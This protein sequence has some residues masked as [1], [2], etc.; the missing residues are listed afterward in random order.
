MKKHRIMVIGLDGLCMKMIQ[1]FASEGII[2]NM[3]RLCR[4]GTLTRMIP[5]VP[6]QTPTNWTTLATGAYPG[7]HGITVWGTHEPG[8]PIDEAFRAEAMSSNLCRAEYFW[9]AAARQGMNSLLVNYVGYPPTSER[10]SFIEW[11]QG[12]AAYYFQI[13]PPGAVRTR[14]ADGGGQEVTFRTA[15]GWKNLPR[16]RRP[17]LETEF[18][19]PP[20]RGGDPAEFHVALIAR[21][22]SGYDTAFVGASKDATRAVHCR[23]GAWSGWLITP[24][25]V[26]SR[27]TEGSVRFKLLDLD[28]RADRVRLYHSQVYPLDQFTYPPHLGAELTRKFGP[29]VHEA[30]WAARH[31]GDLC[32]DATCE[33]E[34]TYFAR[35]VG[36]AARDLFDKLDVR[37]YYQH[38]HLLDS[39]NHAYLSAIDPYGIGYGKRSEKQGW[40][41]FRQGYRMV[42]RMVGEVVKAAD[43]HT[44]IA[45]CSDHSDVPNRRAVSLWNLFLK[46]GWVTLKAG[47]DG[48][49]QIDWKRTKVHHD[50]NHLWLN[51]RGRDPDGCVKP[52]REYEA[53]REE[54]LD[55]MIGLKDRKFAKRPIA[56]ALKKEDAACLGMYGP[57]AGDIVFYYAQGYRWS[58]PEVFRMGRRA[59]IFDDPGGA[60]H[61]PQIPTGQTEI[62]DNAAALILAGPG[63]RRGYV[64]DPDQAPPMSTADLVPTLAHLA[65]FEPPRHCEGKVVHDLL[66]GARLPRSRRRRK[67]AALPQKP[68]RKPTLAGDVTDEL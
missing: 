17:V 3:A 21:G 41:A 39:L 8:T 15:G 34:L 66:V 45:V 5:V 35:W 59:V 52:G 38:Y 25:R 65:G 60:N 6:A 30:A 28:A 49:P 50:Q 58:G 61:G 32:D 31:H 51:V 43:E 4:R 42:D 33:E 11:A 55:A 53:L 29:F 44:L 37:L 2:P 12:P 64:R 27:R 24:F 48:V 18:T 20:V 46:K 22:G 19:V 40:E 14:S 67:I 62:S 26:K 68:R 57:A 23:K 13:A 63:V 54:I 10:T 36:K 1:R 7:T 16:S 56:L 9:E 47:P